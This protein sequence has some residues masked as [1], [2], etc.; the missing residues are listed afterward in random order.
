MVAGQI[1]IVH[2]GIP[3]QQLTWKRKKALSK[4]KVVF[5]Q[6]SVHF[7]VSWWEGNLQLACKTPAAWTRG[8]ETGCSYCHHTWHLA[9][10][11]VESL[12]ARKHLRSIARPVEG[13]RGP[14]RKGKHLAL[15]EGLFLPTPSN[16][17]FRLVLATACCTGTGGDFH[18]LPL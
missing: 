3:S 5:L 15:M 12:D 4:R 17:A 13:K 11:Q 8:P 7:H 6:G 2:K 14:K 18:A 16:A 9:W 1:T 10:A